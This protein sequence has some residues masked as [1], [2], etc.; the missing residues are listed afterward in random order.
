MSKRITR[1]TFVQT[2]A[3]ATA[4]AG[5][6]AAG[7]VQAKESNA[8]IETVHFGCIG[9]GGKGSSDSGDA[10]NNGAVVAICDVDKNRLN[11]A[12]NRFKDAQAFTD[13]RELVDKMG[14]KIDA[15]TVSTPDHNHAAA[16]ALAMHAGKHAFVQKPL[17]HTIGEARFL[18]ELAKKK[19]VQTEMGNQGTAGNGLR[20]GAALVK[21]GALGAIKEVHTWTNRPIWP[22]GG[23]RPATTAVPDFLEWDLWLGPAPERPYANG[24][25]PFAWRGWWDFG[26]GALGDMACHTFN[27]PFAAVDLKDPVSV[28]A[29]HSGHNKDS[30][31]KWSIITFEFP[32]N[33]WRGPVTVKWY[34]GGKRVDPELL[35]K[36]PSGSGCLI[37]G[38]KGKLYSPDDYGG[39]Y[40]L[41]G[42]VDKPTV[43]YEKSPGHFQEFVRAIKTGKPAM[44]NFPDYA[45]PLTETILL[46][47]LAV[48]SGEKVEWDAKNL[49]S[50]NQP[51][52]DKIVNSTYRDGWKL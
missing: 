6:W 13:Y 43:D 19:G 23:D 36:N 1:R 12:K 51:E 48:W 10:A 46:G 16:A 14:D 42:N 35:G 32:K 24:Y 21:A 27:L 50:T 49:K 39:S 28:Q 5:Y 52:L 17:T 47:N 11:G 31:P 38:E 2:S 34:D 9:I 3:A 8:A 25:H 20:E 37:V 44:S 7:G 41:I 29:E 45:G 18:G 15:V 30:Y 26:T 33:D 40:E 4:A 22:Q